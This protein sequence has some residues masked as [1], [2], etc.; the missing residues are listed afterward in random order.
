MDTQ[1]DVVA[2]LRW[3]FFSN[4]PLFVVAYLHS[5]RSTANYFGTKWSPYILQYH[6]DRIITLRFMRGFESLVF[7]RTCA[8]QTNFP[9]TQRG[10]GKQDDEG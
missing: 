8:H 4:V 6:C 1:A 9:P 5:E 3:T 2:S 10:E 7:D